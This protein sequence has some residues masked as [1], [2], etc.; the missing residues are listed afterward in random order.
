MSRLMT[1]KMKLKKNQKGLTLIELLAV[2]VILGVIS[3]IAVPSI[4]GIISSTKEKA[5]LASVEMVK[6]AVLNKVLSE[7]LTAT[8]TVTTIA[9]LVTEGYLATAPEWNGDAYVNYSASY[10]SNVWTIDVVDPTP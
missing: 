1:M 2:I 8:P 6:A 9:S 10:A 5:D 3:A 4:T 7:N